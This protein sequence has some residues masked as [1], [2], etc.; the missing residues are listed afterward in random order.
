MISKEFIKKLAIKYQTTEL[1]IKREYIQHLFLSYF[2]QTPESTNVFFKGGT[3]LK[4]IYQSPRFSED[5][6]F[7]SCINKKQIEDLIIMT[8]QEIRREGVDVEIIESKKTSGGYLAKL[9]F[10]LGEDRIGMMIQISQRSKNKKSETITIVN[11]FLPAYILVMLEKEELIKEKVIAL[12]TR[13][14]PRDFYDLY[15]ILRANLLPSKEKKLLVDVLAKVKKTKI[16][17][18]RELKFFLPKNHWLMIKNFKMNLEKEI[19]RII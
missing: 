15:F 11:D 3:A 14:K 10:H 17:F 6:D 1:N 18:N 7:S 4:I 16:D 9:I 8:L 19:L 2:Y 12:L 5:L 13:G